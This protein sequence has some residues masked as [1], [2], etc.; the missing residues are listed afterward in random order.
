MIQLGNHLWAH[1]ADCGRLVKLTGW[2][3]GWHLCLTD[4]EIA[5]KRASQTRVGSH[6]N[7][8][9]N[10]TCGSAQSAAPKSLHHHD[11]PS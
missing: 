2:L 4:E 8:V 5:A 6:G 1:C 3:R 11:I 7:Q 10:G 9:S